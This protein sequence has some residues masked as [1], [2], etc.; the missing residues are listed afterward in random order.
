ME[1]QQH[2]W[3]NLRDQATAGE[4]DIDPEVGRTSSAAIQQMIG[5]Y[6]DVLDGS[7]QMAHV[8]GLGDFAEG[9]ELARLLGLKAF[10]PEGDGDLYHAVEDHIRVLKLM[11]ETIQASLNRL[12]EQDEGNSEQLGGAGPES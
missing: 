7:Q 4:L 11:D 10:D 12:A 2:L 1:D 3:E 8:T 5:V 9:H 6:E